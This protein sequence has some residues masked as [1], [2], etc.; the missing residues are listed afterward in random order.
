MELEVSEYTHK[1]SSLRLSERTA[2]EAPDCYMESQV[3]RFW[4]ALLTSGMM[5]LLVGCGTTRTAPVSDQSSTAQYKRY[6]TYYR[7]SKGETLYS[8]AWRTHLDFRELA[9]WNGIKPPQYRIY[10]GQHLRLKPPKP[11]KRSTVK[12][13]PQKLERKKAPPAKKTI[14]KN[15]N[16]QS[17]ANSIEALKIS[18]NWPTNGSVIRAFSKADRS[19]QGIRIAGRAGQHIRAAASGKVVYSGSGLIGYGNLIIIKHNSTYLSAYA[20]NRRILVKEGETVSRGA[21]IAEMGRAADD[22][23]PLLHFEIRRKG[24]PINPVALLPER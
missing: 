18:W 24:V 20:H 12:K 17:V 23:V 19:R 5:L 21:V 15:K 2:R 4:L 13:K 8:I 14:S 1:Q 7:V 10:P 9:A 11:I 16:E 3:C 22:K 6:K